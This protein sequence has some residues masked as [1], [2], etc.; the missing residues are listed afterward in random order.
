[1]ESLVKMERIINKVYARYLNPVEAFMIHLKIVF[2]SLGI[3]SLIC[4]LVNGG[5][6]K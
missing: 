1:M 3:I 4:Y 2:C 5:I 6:I